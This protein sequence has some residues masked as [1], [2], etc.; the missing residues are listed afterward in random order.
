MAFVLTCSDLSKSFGS[1]VIFENISFQLEEN[2]KLGILGSNGTGKSTL[3]K[4][5]VGE[6]TPDSGTVTLAS[7][8]KLGYLAQYQKD[9]LSG[10]I[11]DIVLSA[12]EDLIREEAE[13]RDMEAKMSTVSGDELNKL[14]ESYHAKSESF[15]AKGGLFFRSE[16]G[17][18]LKGLG[19]TEEDFTKSFNQ[20]SGGQK[21]RVSL[22]RLLAA[23]P[24]VLL[25]D[26]P[27]N[28]LD[29]HSIEWLETFLSNYSGAVILVAHD[30][31]FLN[32]TID[33]ALDLSMHPAH[34]FTGNY[35]AYTEQ[36]RDLEV[37]LEREYEKQQKE[38]AHQEAVITKLQ[39][40]NR[41]K[42]IKRAESRKKMLDK[43]DRIEK[44]VEEE[45]GMH[46]VLEPNSRSGNDVLDVS[47]L[48]KSFDGIKLFSNLNFHIMRQER[49]AIL[50]DNGTGKTTTLK[51][52]NGLL[53]ADS[54]KVHIGTGVTIGY[55][56]QE[57]Q[58]LNEDAT[59]FDELQNAYPNLNNTK[60]RS[61]LAAFRFKGDHVYKKIRDLSGGERGRVS[62]AKLMLSG[63][64]FLI[65]DEPTNHLDMESKEILEEALNAY[66]GTL[67]Y[68]SHDRYFINQTAQRILEIHPDGLREYL[69]NYDYYLQKKA[70]EAEAASSGSGSAASAA[71]SENGV[72]SNTGEESASGNK[73][74]GI[75]YQEQKKRKAA[76]KKLERA[77][78]DLEEN[79]SSKEERIS[80]IDAS[81]EDEAIA[82]NSA[83]LN[84]LTQE[85]SK[86]EE[87]LED[88]YAKW[89]SL[90]M[91]LDGE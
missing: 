81:F 45:T 40:F 16:A 48:S 76:R 28:H 60:V 66:T 24:D 38:I 71:V 1:D 33:H 64:N 34:L 47:D 68:V 69:G 82:K 65:L 35:K 87:E 57:Q 74:S 36:K 12:R 84:E 77:L 86:L 6:I 20:L 2:E 72:L 53:P 62:L 80:E 10:S 52:I 70:E 79:I 54:G 19:F 49:V 90:S 23:K 21:T 22:G 75:D 63:A 30:R 8:K 26:E 32:R 27:I 83:K 46:L 9:D 4:T 89:E 58:N 44:P 25:L 67:L 13:L 7:G 11:Y 85:R 78:S 59:L 37:T 31:Y 73:D 18:V 14:I 29:L 91:E 42:S 56:D 61:I 50:G 15:E 51:I 43:I 5:I 3:L 88:A 17:G 41:E 55:Y 39:S